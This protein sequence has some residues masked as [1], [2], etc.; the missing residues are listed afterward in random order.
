MEQ[1]D[2]GFGEKYSACK[3]KSN[4]AH[5]DDSKSGVDAIFS[6]RDCKQYDCT[7]KKNQNDRNDN[8]GS[9]KNTRCEISG[10]D[11]STVHV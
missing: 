11:G 10:C 2:A 3:G 6:L 5:T 8:S 1:Q 7:Q 9:R 4:K